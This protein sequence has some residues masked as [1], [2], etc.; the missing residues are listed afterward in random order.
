M[1]ARRAP[2][3]SSN[4]VPILSLALS[5]AATAPAA[6]EPGDGWSTLVRS[7]ADPFLSRHKWRTD[8]E[9][10]VPSQAA[11]NLATLLSFEV[12]EPHQL[13]SSQNYVVLVGAPRWTDIFLL[14]AGCF[15]VAD[16]RMTIT[17]RGECDLTNTR[18]VNSTSVSVIGIKTS[19]ANATL[20][21]EVITR[22][23]KRLDVLGFISFALPGIAAAI[24]RE[25]T[26]SYRY[27]VAVDQ[28]AIGRLP[29]DLEVTASYARTKAQS[30]RPES[31]GRTFGNYP[32]EHVSLGVGLGVRSVTDISLNL[33]TNTLVATRISKLKTYALVGLHPRGVDPSAPRTWRAPYAVGALEISPE[34]FNYGAGV[35]WRLPFIDNSALAVTAIHSLPDIADSAKAATSAAA[36]E[37]RV[38]FMVHYTF[39]LSTS[40]RQK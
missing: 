11:E 23:R 22:K 37:W 6:G 14:R 26:G 1:S 39:P 9:G 31:F 8:H 33:S 21:W 29:V 25:T 38:A 30:A 34:R 15:G 36:R 5:L 24:P 16:G 4:V 32:D 3:S 13:H 20:E 19:D 2:F 10:D 27:D 28:L 40:D 18:I 7:G 17:E 12:G 35:G